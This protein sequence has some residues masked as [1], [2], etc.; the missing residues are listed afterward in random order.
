MP[1]S[2]EAEAL[3]AIAAE[4]VSCQRCPRL[5]EHCRR[6]AAIKR[7]AYRDWVYWGQ[8][9]PSFGDPEARLLLVGLAPGAHGANRTGRVFTGDSSGDF[10]YRALYDTG[11]ASQPSST[12]AGDGLMLKDCYIASA[13]RCAPPQNRPLPAEFQ[14]CRDF[15]RREIQQLRRLRAVLV[16]GRLALDAYLSAMISQGATLRKRDYQF[17]HGAVHHPPGIGM[18]LLCSYHP[19]RQ[20]TQTGRL[21]MSMMTEVLRLAKSRLGE[22]FQPETANFE[23]NKKNCSKCATT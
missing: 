15:L 14:A 4:I 18:A 2:K 12:A 13:V 5:V 7:K 21:T 6:V 19:S 3:A 22:C 17:A 20:N 9:V 16:L 8:P 10:L 23:Q 1:R 11:F